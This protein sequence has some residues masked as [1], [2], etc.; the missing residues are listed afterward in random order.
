MWK[1][2]EVADPLRFLTLTDIDYAKL[3]ALYQT[4][5][6]S[7]IIEKNGTGSNTDQYKVR[8]S[9]RGDN[10]EDRQKYLLK[11]Y[12]TKAFQDWEIW[13]DT[14][15]AANIDPSF[16]MCIGLSETTLGNHLKTPYNIGNVGNTD[17]GDTMTF[18]S[19]REG[20]AWMA[21]TF[22]N[23]YLGKYN[24]ISDLSRWGNKN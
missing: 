3:P 11:T 7:D 13:T 15:L 14:A 6:I 12:A 16:M 24:K 2:K 20:I 18:A 23:K 21:K 8:F 9:L 17:S 19:A 22:N 1:N 5:F 4:K 10:E